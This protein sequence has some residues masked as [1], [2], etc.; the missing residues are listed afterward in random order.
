LE[1]Y[2]KDSLS[3]DQ[4][5]WCK[6]WV[7][8]R[9]RHKKCPVAYFEASHNYWD[10]EE[11]QQESQAM[12]QKRALHTNMSKDSSGEEAV[13]KSTSASPSTGTLG[14][15]TSKVLITASAHVC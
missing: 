12:T 11:G 6:H 13:A 9:E 4:Y 7:Q 1:K 15:S 14:L 10:S 8:H 2:L 5:K 3:K